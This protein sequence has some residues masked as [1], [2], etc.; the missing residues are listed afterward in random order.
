MHTSIDQDS[1]RLYEAL[2]WEPTGGYFLLDR[3]LDRLAASARHFGYAIEI[4]RVRAALAAH[5]HRLTDSPRK[6]R[7]EV[8]YQG[9]LEIEDLLPKP[10]GPITAALAREP[11]DSADPFLRHKTS[12]REPYVR[13][14]AA[15]PGA[16]DVV[17]WNEREELTESCVANLVLEIDGR[18]LTPAIS[19]GLL[20]GTFRAHLLEQGEIEEAVL[21]RDAL[22]QANRVYIINSVRHWCEIKWLTDTHPGS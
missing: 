17:L 3:H 1:F 4:D 12:R 16:Q 2:L 18:R 8:D 19:S 7:L 10:S 13:A 11:I 9:G 20:P 22:A 6:I 15:H 14:L 5:A 21:L